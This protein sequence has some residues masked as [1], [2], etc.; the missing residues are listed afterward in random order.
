MEQYD[1]KTVKRL[2]RIELEIYRDLKAV[3]ERH[4][5]PFF[6]YYGT[7]LGAVRHQGFIPWDDDIDVA[8]FR[9]DYERFTQIAAKELGDRYDLLTMDTVDGYVMGLAKL[10][11]KGTI[12]VEATDQD[13]KY[14]SGVFLDIFPLDKAPEDEKL[15]K[16]V[17]RSTW[18]WGRL[19]VLSEYKSPKLPANLSK[20][21][22]I[23]AK[24][25][26]F[27]I[28]YLLKIF[29]LTQRKCYQHYLKAATQLRNSDAT[30]YMDYA[31]PLA[32]SYPIR[33]DDI[34]PLKELAFEDT[35]VM[36]PGNYDRVLTQMYGDYMTLPPVDQRINHIPAVLDLGN[37]GVL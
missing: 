34:L 36:V 35:T 32:Y 10:S 1:Q 7:I 22:V 13:R 12:F 30:L 21:K 3:C 29:R 11:H 5:I 23:C 28:H 15:R 37:E 26:C 6:V 8:M 16:K 9:E 17:T 24:A 25:G 14:R 4:N 19:G 20:G 31:S 33:K 2:H 18:L 27:I